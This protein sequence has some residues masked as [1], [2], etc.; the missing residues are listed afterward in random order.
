MSEGEKWQLQLREDR[1]WSVRCSEQQQQIQSQ[2]HRDSQHHLSLLFIQLSGLF[3]LESLPLLRWGTCCCCC[4]LCVS[5]SIWVCWIKLFAY[6]LWLILEGWFGENWVRL[7]PSTAPLHL[8]VLCPS[9]PRMPP[10]VQKVCLF[11]QC[12]VVFFFKFNLLRKMLHWWLSSYKNYNYHRIQV[13]VFAGKLIS[14]TLIYV[15]LTFP[16][17]FLDLG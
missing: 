5:F 11:R 10:S 17:C 7:V 14:S 9:F 16:F 15:A 1:R 8:L 13:A 4:S 3:A 2:L 12:P 6:E